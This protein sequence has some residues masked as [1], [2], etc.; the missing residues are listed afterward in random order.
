MA[1]MINTTANMKRKTDTT[2]RNITRTVNMTRIED[3]VVRMTVATD[4]ELVLWVKSLFLILQV[5]AFCLCLLVLCEF[6]KHVFLVF[7]FICAIFF[8][9]TKIKLFFKIVSSFQIKS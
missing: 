5:C 3:A 7:L 1:N 6:F 9:K 4:A 2:T 8:S